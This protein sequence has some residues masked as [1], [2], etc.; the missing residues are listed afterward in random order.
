MLICGAVGAALFRGDNQ[1]NTALH[2]ATWQNH[3]PTV[4]FLCYKGQEFTRSI[5]ADK[6]PARKGATFNQIA[7]EL[8]LELQDIKLRPVETRRFQKVWIHE[9]ACMFREKMDP[10]VRHMLAPTCVEIMEDVLHRF[11]PRPETGT[12]HLPLL[13]HGSCGEA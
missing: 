1:G 7:Q 12:T 4:D 9:A 2:L 11:D 6:V 13:S 8:F 3:P 10:K 5:T